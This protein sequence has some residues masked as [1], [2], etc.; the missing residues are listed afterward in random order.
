MKKTFTLLVT[1]F[2]L[3]SLLVKAQNKVEKTQDDLPLYQGI[4]EVE[5]LDKNKLYGQLREWVAV[6]YKSAKDVIQMDDPRLGKIVLKGLYTYNLET[7]GTTFPNKVYHMITLEA[8][9]GRFRYTIEITDVT[10][11]TVD[12]SILQDV[13]L[14]ETPVKA[15]GKPYT[16]LIL[17]N[18]QKQK[19]QHLE[20]ISTFKDN[21]ISSLTKTSESKSDNDW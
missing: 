20:R 7:M 3:T 17:K 8:K 1:T 16:G 15:N 4:I 12:Q 21:L 13:L 14:P 11:G 6:N 9:D 5:G 19:A 2:L 10:T 18:V